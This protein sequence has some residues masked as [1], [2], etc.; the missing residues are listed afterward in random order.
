MYTYPFVVSTGQVHTE[1]RHPVSWQMTSFFL[2]EKNVRGAILADDPSAGKLRVAKFGKLGSWQFC[3]WPFWDGENLTFWKGCWWPPTIGD[4]KV[5]NWI[6]W[7][8]LLSWFVSWW[9][10]NRGTL[11]CFFCWYL[12]IDSLGNP[13]RYPCTKS[14]VG[15]LGRLVK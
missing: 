9:V 15:C 13:N 2:G 8:M 6:T 10:E 12:R 14:E 5:T 7:M 1:G 4:Q 11:G 3:W